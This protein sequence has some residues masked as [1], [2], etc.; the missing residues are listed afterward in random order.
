MILL[1][2][3]IL[4]ETQIDATGECVSQTVSGDVFNTAIALKH[5]GLFAFLVSRL[6]DD[7]PGATIRATLAEHEISQ[8][9]ITT[10]PHRFTGQYTLF[11]PQPSTTPPTITPPTT[12][13]T[14][15][16]PTTT[17]STTTPTILYQRAHSAACSLHPADLPSASTAPQW[18]AVMATG[19]TLALSASSRKTV[20]AAFKQARKGDTPTYLDL[21]YRAPLWLRPAM[22]RAAIEAL[23][24]WVDTLKLTYPDDV[25]AWLPEATSPEDAARWAM[26]CGVPCVL[27]TLG[28]GGVLAARRLAA[29]R[30]IAWQHFAIPPPEDF[31][32]APILSVLGAGDAFNA[33]MLAGMVT[34]LPF[35]EAVAQGQHLA[36]QVVR[37]PHTALVPTY[38]KKDV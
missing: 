31:D 17:P 22:A 6:G 35:P 10:T 4:L 25:Q 30:R 19:I 38:A 33:G 15:T 32:G 26:A 13:L 3:E 7:T 37:N 11:L 36:G 28:A 1:L 21:N 14:T 8:N 2:G 27:V 5:L 9:Y 20:W 18:Q 29:N 34:H 23:L 24:P 16:P 12:T